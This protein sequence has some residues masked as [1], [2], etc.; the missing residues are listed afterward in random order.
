MAPITIRNVWKYYGTDPAVRDLNIECSDGSFV[1][2][3]GPRVAANP[4]PCG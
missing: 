3:L 4:R 1:S 2:I